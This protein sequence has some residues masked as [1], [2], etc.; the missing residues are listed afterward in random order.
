[1]SL[2]MEQSERHERGLATP[3]SLYEGSESL[4]GL[5]L[6]ARGEP[7][8][9]GPTPL[10]PYLPAVKDQQRQVA[11]RHESLFMSEESIPQNIDEPMSHFIHDNNQSR[12][13]HRI[14]RNYDSYQ[15]RG[16]FDLSDIPFDALDITSRTLTGHASPAEIIMVSDILE[17]PT[18]ELGTI[19]IPYG[20]RFEHIQPM[21]RAVDEGILF[22]GGELVSSEPVFQVKRANYFDNEYSGGAQGLLMTRSITRGYIGNNIECVE[23]SSFVVMLDY[24]GLSPNNK[25]ELKKDHHEDRQKHVAITNAIMETPYGKDWSDTILN[26]PGFEEAILE[27][28]DADDFDV[29]VPISMTAFAVNHQLVEKYLKNTAHCE[30]RQL[31]MA[32]NNPYP[33]NQLL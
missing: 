28:F 2:S 29:V 21:R 27:A 18:I 19:A 4:L 32:R 1:M 33:T 24:L 13:Q 6:T 25:K 14:Q 16:K 31:A 17:V 9:F 30:A 11:E 20:Q 10:D 12:L 22:H 8:T 15:Y 26:I 7:E 23:R 5:E 3:A